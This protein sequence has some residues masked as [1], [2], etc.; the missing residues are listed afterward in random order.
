M[1]G[2]TSGANTT[3][4]GR[5]NPSMLGSSNKTSSMLKPSYMTSS[6]SSKRSREDEYDYQSS[7]W[8]PEENSWM[9]SNNR[10][11]NDKNESEREKER[12]R[13]RRS[14]WGGD[15]KEKVFIPGLPTVLPN[16]LNPQQERAYLLQL[17]IEEIS[18][19][20]RTGD[21]GIP[22]NPE[23]RS[24]SPEPI[25]NSEGKRLNT[26]EYR[27]RKKLEDDRHNLIQEMYQCNPEYK[28]PPDYKPPLVKVCEKVMI[29]QEEHPDINF[30]GLLIGPRGNT[31][32]SMEKETGAKIIIRGKGSVKEGKVGRKDGQP[33][34]GEDEPLHAFV[35]GNSHES[36]K[37]A[38]NKIKDIIRQ[39]V[40]VPEGQNDLRRMQLRE[41]ALLNGTLREN[42][43]PRCTNCG[44]TTHR[45]WQCPDKPNVTNNVICSN[46][47]SAG[48]IS[49]DC[50]E[51]KAPGALGAPDKAKIDEEYMSLM[52][53]LGEGPPPPNKTNS[54]G[55]SSHSSI[56]P[57]QAP[58]G[59][60]RAIMAPPPS[61]STSQF[62]A[63]SSQPTFNNAQNKS[64][65]IQ[66]VPPPTTVM[67]NTM[68]MPPPIMSQ[69][70]PPPMP[71]S[72]T[73]SPMGMPPWAQPPFQTPPGTA[74]QPVM[75]NQASSAPAVGMLAPPPPP[76]NLSAGSQ[77][78]SWMTPPTVTQAAAPWQMPHQVSGPMPVP[79]PPGIA[80]IPPPAA[81]A[82]MYPWGGFMGVPPPPPM[83]AAASL[84]TLAAQ[85]PPPPPP[86]TSSVQSTT[87]P[88]TT[89]NVSLATLS[90][91]SLLTAPPPPPPPP[92]S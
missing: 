76:P 42:D 80:P 13:K 47:G 25:Y 17:Q 75:P 77:P 43:G 21:L 73:V 9:S 67:Q 52:A 53:E 3:P 71:P 28:P 74:Q 29:P 48:H 66:S 92:P 78:H 69:M 60:P 62:Q 5:P 27:T 4:L 37:K 7:K 19:R 70:P 15:E 72:S 23:E 83:Q 57:L 39:G 8:P 32:K 68:F 1:S 54:V 55:T 2:R 50:R 63:T 85:P 56:T 90:L 26:R 41:L 89:Q 59:P 51:Q 64:S 10:N 87:A 11:N 45:S 14:R 82:T 33:L 22:P 18:R 36:V 16:N 24:P 79:P 61:I 44:G 20:L 86:A 35:T 65:A 81:M 12:K 31:L 38:V 30:V 88:A 58:P 40:E 34:P 46:C 49:K 84:Q 91:P 6:D